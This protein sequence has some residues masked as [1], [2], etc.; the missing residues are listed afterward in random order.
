MKILFKTPFSPK[1]RWIYMGVE[2]DGAA[3]EGESGAENNTTEFELWTL[4][5]EFPI[6]PVEDTPAQLKGLQAQVAEHNLSVSS[7]KGS[8]AIYFY[9]RSFCRAS[10]ANPAK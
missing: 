8:G 3:S 9:G 5:D 7:E 4:Q 6:H 2:L 1:F 10:R